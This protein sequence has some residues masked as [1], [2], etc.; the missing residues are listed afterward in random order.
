MF[1]IISMPPNGPALWVAKMCMALPTKVLNTKFDTPSSLPN[2]LKD[3]IFSFIKK[4]DLRSIYNNAKHHIP[5]VQKNLQL[6]KCRLGIIKINWQIIEQ[7]NKKQLAGNVLDYINQPLPGR[8]IGFEETEIKYISQQVMVFLNKW[9]TTV[10]NSCPL[11]VIIP[12]GSDRMLEFVGLKILPFPRTTNG[13]A[14]STDVIRVIPSILTDCPPLRCVVYLHKNMA[15][16]T[17]KFAALQTLV[18]WLCPSSA[19]PHNS[20]LLPLKKLKFLCSK[21]V[22]LAFIAQLKKEFRSATT[23][24]FRFIVVFWHPY[25]PAEIPTFSIR[26][27]FTGEHMSIR[28]NDNQAYT[29]VRQ[30]EENKIII[31]LADDDTEEGILEHEP[32][33]ASSSGQQQQK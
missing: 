29:L 20:D 30:Y 15:T 22:A 3:E 8:V 16:E 31:S 23:S 10:F 1:R 24:R 2:E 33:T 17:A 7:Q 26:N 21:K 27:T 14:F 32:S 25:E 18:N 28:Q 5:L 12:K 13:L 9:R 4:E 19:L 6:R 11:C